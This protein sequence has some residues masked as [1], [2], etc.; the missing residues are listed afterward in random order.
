V[1]AGAVILWTLQKKLAGA[2]DPDDVGR[3]SDGRM[4][5][6]LLLVC[7]VLA[8]IAGRLIGYTSAILG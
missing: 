1:V 7:W 3:S 8:M 6:G 5:A 2:D 4:L